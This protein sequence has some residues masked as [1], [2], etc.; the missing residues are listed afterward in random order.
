MKIDAHIHYFPPMEPEEYETFCRRNPYWSLLVAPRSGRSIQGWATAERT[1]RD[2]DVAGI[3]RAIIQGEYRRQHDACVSRNDLALELVHRFPDRFEAFAMLQPLAGQKALDELQRCLD[4]GLKGVGELNAYAQG[5]TLHHPDFLRLVEACIRAGVPLNLHVSEEVG[6]HY[7]GKSTTPLR[8]FYWLA[9][10]YPDLKL[11]LAHWGGGLLF[12]EIA[13]T[14]RCVLSNVWYDTAASPLLYP[15]A[16]IFNVALQCVD[17]HKILMGSD[18]PLLLYPSRHEQPNFTTFLEEIAGLEL[19]PTVYADIMGL[20]AARV[21]GLV[22]DETETAPKTNTT[23]MRKRQGPVAENIKKTMPVRF[24]AEHWP[25][26][27]AVFDR[28]GIPWQDQ[29][30][31]FWEQIIQ[32]AAARGL[33]E[34]DQEKLLNELNEAIR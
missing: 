11:I 6:H 3:D 9:S 1:L 17:H 14:V 5:F 16:R 2:M 18:Y 31:P 10:E 12:Y 28:Y 30:V 19:E 26:T 13:P 15:T 33:G 34:E 21:L 20:N 7:P 24:V 32:A 22:E 8:E 29:P 27:Q 4:G 25:D 23:I